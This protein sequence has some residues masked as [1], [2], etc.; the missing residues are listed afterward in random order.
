MSD[1]STPDNIVPIQPATEAPAQPEQPQ[2][3]TLQQLV[4]EIPIENVTEHEIITD[5]IAGI[6]Q[7]AIRGSIA[8]GLLERLKVAQSEQEDTGGTADED[9]AVS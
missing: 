6:Q 5:L 8:L 9:Q 4:A 2:G 1:T 7:L 3:K